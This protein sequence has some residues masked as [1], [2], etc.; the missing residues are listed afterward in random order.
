MEEICIHK[1]PLMPLCINEISHCY[2]IS[3]LVINPTC[4]RDFK[5]I[6]VTEGYL[7]LNVQNTEYIINTGEIVFIPPYCSYFAASEKC[8]IIDLMFAADM[9]SA[10]CADSININYIQPFMSHQ[11]IHA[12]IFN[13]DNE[14]YCKIKFIIEQIFY[15]Y[16]NMNIGY[17]LMV[18]SYL[19]QIYSIIIKCIKLPSA[20]KNCDLIKS[21][22]TYIQINCC[23][24]ITRKSIADFAGIT[25]DYLNE[26][27]RKNLKLTPMAYRN[28][29]RVRECAA[30]LISTDKPIADIARECGFKSIRTFNNQFIEAIGITPCQFRKSLKEGK[31]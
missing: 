22:L 30:L 26:L 6:F 1:N 2:N 15:E 21:I 24:H 13:C 8:S 20:N 12:V 11:P 28:K 16:T 7:K 23:N 18:K 27:L 10:D 4:H 31:I 17:E 9:L 3:K 19:C 5:F 25:S 14:F 29:C